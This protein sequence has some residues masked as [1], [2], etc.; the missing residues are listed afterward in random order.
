[1]AINR[2]VYIVDDDN[3]VRA[4][5]LFFL[6]SLGM[7]PQAFED[8]AG[9]LAQLADL[10]PGCV[11]L[12]IRMPGIDG[13]QVIEALAGRHAQLP[14]VVVTGHGDVVTAV[15]AMKLG[16]CDFVEKPFEEELLLSILERVFASLDE[17]VAT[18]ERRS[19]A[20]A[21]LQS[22]TDRE[23]DVLR[24]LVAGRSNKLLAHDLGVSVRTIEMH[25]SHMMDRLGV[26]S[27]AEALRLAFVAGVELELS[28]PKRGR[29]NAA[30]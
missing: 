12:D 19:Q 25:R 29:E 17:N 28:L 3:E 14:I 5:T 16:A 13:F 8:G 6:R 11:L 2:F 18:D 23:D 21:L 30:A 9:L 15:R 1:M 4:S 20:I 22:L 24:G 26:H 7:S 27:L 10:R